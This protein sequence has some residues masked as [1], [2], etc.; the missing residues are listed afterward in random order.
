MPT[1]Y[2]YYR[3]DER[4]RIVELRVTRR[5]EADGDRAGVRY[6]RGMTRDL[7]REFVRLDDLPPSYAEP[8][9]ERLDRTGDREGIVAV[10]SEAHDTES[11]GVGGA[12]PGTSNDLEGETP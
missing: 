11:R 2:L 10:S 6:G 7:S 3:I 1:R 12:E 4:D 9:R 5:R 8:V